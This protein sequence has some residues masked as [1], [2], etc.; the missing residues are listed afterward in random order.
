[1]RVFGTQPGVRSEPGSRSR[2]TAGSHDGFLGALRDAAGA[3]AAAAPAPALPGS[4]TGVLA[5]QEAPSATDRPARRRAIRRAESLLDALEALRLH[6]V[7]GAIPH[8]RLQALVGLLHDQEPL[9]DDPDLAAVIAEIELRA[10]V[11]LAKHAARG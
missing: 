6:I 7:A 1:M 9:D 4:V 11:E 8:Q 10:A 3:G 2:Q 5:V